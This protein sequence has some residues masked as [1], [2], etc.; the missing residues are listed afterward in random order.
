MKLIVNPRRT[1][2][3]TVTPGVVDKEGN[4][5]KRPVHKLFGPTYRI[6]VPDEEAEFL[7]GCGAA[8]KDEPAPVADQTAPDESGKVKTAK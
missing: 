2:R 8:R 5:T 7:I 3:I 1:V 4:I 6:D